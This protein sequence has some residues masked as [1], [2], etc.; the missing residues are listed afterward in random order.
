MLF[1]EFGGRQ[2]EVD[3]RGYLVD[4]FAWERKMAEVM[5][6]ND[7]LTLTEA[8][9]EI[10]NFLRN[11]YEKYWISPKIKIMVKEVGK[12]LGWE[13]GNTRYLYNLFPDG[14]AETS[15]R[16]AGIPNPTT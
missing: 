1:L 10:I 6:A 11:Y 13:K 15:C 14:P 16:Y 4:P 8:H 12:A 5:A 9:W 7:G 2:I 3:E